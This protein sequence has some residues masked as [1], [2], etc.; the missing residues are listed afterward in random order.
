VELGDDMTTTFTGFCG[1]EGCGSPVDWAIGPGLCHSDY[2]AWRGHQRWEAR[3][4]VPIST[5]E[6]WLEA[7]KLEVHN[8]D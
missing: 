8:G 2:E 7:E 3:A 6:E 4:G 5:I 1:I